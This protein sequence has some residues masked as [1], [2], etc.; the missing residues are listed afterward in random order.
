[1]SSKLLLEND[2]VRPYGCLMG[3]TPVEF[4]PH[5]SKFAKTAVLPSS[6]YTDPND[7]SYG[8]ESDF[9]VT[10]KYGYNPDLSK[11]DLAYIL[12]GIKP[13]LITLT[14]ISLFENEKFDVVKFDV[15]PCENLLKIRT[16][17]DEFK[18]EDKYPT[19]VPHAT[20]A[21]VRKGMFSAKKENLNI[22]VPIS[23]FKYSGSDGKKLMISL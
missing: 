4:K 11:K 15:H 13:F 10:N 18:N 20:I 12:N 5:F 16:R 22:K 14:G 2:A 3:Y 7:P 23:R 19:Y 21:Y 6:I 1:M 17:C 8:Y 9:H